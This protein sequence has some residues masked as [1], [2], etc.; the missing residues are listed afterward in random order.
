MG[1]IQRRGW[2]GP[3]GGHVHCN[4]FQASCPS[5][6]SPYWDPSSLTPSSWRAR[7]PRAAHSPQ[8]NS[9]VLLHKRPDQACWA[10]FQHPSQNL[11]IKRSQPRISRALTPQVCVLSPVSR[12]AS[13]RPLEDYLL[14]ESSI[15][16]PPGSQPQPEDRET[17]LVESEQEN[18]PLDGPARSLTGV[19]SRVCKAWERQTNQPAHA[20]AFLFRLRLFCSDFCLL[21]LSDLEKAG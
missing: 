15:S 18:E 17:C 9:H 6:R 14:L 16:I 10:S 20:R 4:V 7:T 12:A 2:G 3:P 19:R 1:A 13:W 8:A 21:C 11:L 5:P